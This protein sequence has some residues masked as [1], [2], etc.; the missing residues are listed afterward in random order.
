MI[1]KTAKEQP[2]LSV[3][4]R[5]RALNPDGSIGAV[6]IGEFDGDRAKDLSLTYRQAKSL[7][8]QINAHIPDAET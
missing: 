4:F 2:T 6:E 3:L 5:K 7:A 1:E 8:K